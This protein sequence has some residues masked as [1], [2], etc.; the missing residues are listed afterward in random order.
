MEI[1]LSYKRRIGSMGGIEVGKGVKLWSTID[2]TQVLR[3]RRKMHG[4]E[5][6]THLHFVQTLA[7]NG[8]KGLFVL[9]TRHVLFPS[10]WRSMHPVQAIDGT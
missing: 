8:R 5:Y 6:N 2:P 3:G 7:W 1:A 9:S 10:F 4:E